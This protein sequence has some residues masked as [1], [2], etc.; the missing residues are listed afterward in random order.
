MNEW[1]LA[2]AKARLTSEQPN[3][4]RAARVVEFLMTWAD[5]NSDGWM[6]WPGPGN[7]A[8]SLCDALERGANDEGGQDLPLTDLRKA[9]RPVKAFCTRHH[10]AH[11]PYLTA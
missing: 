1:D 6:F 2:D 10:I 11:P 5:E 3:L 9:L 7:A 4:Q 8:R